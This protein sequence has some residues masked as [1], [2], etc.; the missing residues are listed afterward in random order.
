MINLLALAWAGIMAFGVIMYVLLD[1]FDLGIG[2]MLLFIQDEHER[3][4][5]ISSILPLW[6]G[7]QTWLVFGGAALYGAF[8]IAFSTILPILYIPILIMV[9][10]LLFRGIAF[11]FRLKATKSKKFWDICFFLG[12][13]FATIVQGLVL[14]T[15][16]QGFKGTSVP[17]ATDIYQWF[18]PFSLT[19]SL[20]LICGYILLGA[21]YL[22][23][24]TESELQ[25]YF[26]WVANKMQYFILLAFIIVSVW[27]PW[28]DPFIKERWFN[29]K[30]IPYLAILP[31][32]TVILFVTH[33]H[34][35]KKQY[36]HTPFW[37]TIGMFMTCY[38]GFIISTYP[39]IVPRKITYIDAAT[40]DSALLFML[41]GACIML[42]P[43]LIYTYHAHK[44]F[45]GKVTEKLGY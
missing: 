19:C 27:S 31:A 18:N 33:W 2:I 14:G 11:E 40:N 29:I 35:L 30:N 17:G 15:F 4:L 7:N 39:Y 22:I 41:I 42:P 3:D 36:E 45:G 5:M 32:L 13:L 37:C 12:S 8:P 20:A 21:N 43:L 10:A 34:S 28:L 38:L 26:F 1:G 44:I 9:I 6:D 24:K 16:V 25:T 23:I